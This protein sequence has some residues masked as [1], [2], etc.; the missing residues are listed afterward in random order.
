M[1]DYLNVVTYCGLSPSVTT[2]LYYTRCIELYA[3]MCALPAGALPVPGLQ[4]EGPSNPFAFDVLGVA[5]L[6]LMA[7]A[8]LFGAAVVLLDVGLLQLLRPAWRRI[9]GRR[10][11]QQQGSRQR[12]GAG[13]VGV[14][15][16][17]VAVVVEGAGAAD[18]QIS[19][20]LLRNAEDG[21]S[22]GAGGVKLNGVH[23][24]D[25]DKEDDDVAAERQAVEAAEGLDEAL[26]RQHAACSEALLQLE[27]V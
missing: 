4:P 10:Q 22:S 18:L 17:G 7:Q 5:V 23:G 8:L 3:L 1:L 9:T 19:E 15:S 2:P 24:G 21:G 25:G 27:A 26:V 13:A 11:Q 16:R 20:P 14:D 6:H 12:T